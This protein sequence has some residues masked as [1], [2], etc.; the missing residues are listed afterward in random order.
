VKDE[1][2]EG[3]SKLRKIWYIATSGAWGFCYAHLIGEP[4][5]AELSVIVF[6]IFGMLIMLIYMYTKGE[7]SPS[8]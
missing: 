5:M 3:M 7:F 4:E 2:G 6:M 1:E 8:K